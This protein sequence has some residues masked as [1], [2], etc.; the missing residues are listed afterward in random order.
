MIVKVFDFIKSMDEPCVYKK[1]NESTIVFLVLYVYN[2]LLTRNDIPMLQL[3]KTWLSNKFFM[4]E[5]DEAFYVLGIKIYEDRSKKDARL[6]LVSV[7]RSHV[8][9]VQ[10]GGK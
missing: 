9:E 7:H 6:V 3:V 4:K 1:I 2:I 8:E 10:H 5:L